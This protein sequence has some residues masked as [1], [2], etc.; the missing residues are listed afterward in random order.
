MEAAPRDSEFRKNVLTAWGTYKL[1][2]KVVN[3]AIGD[4]YQN[5]IDIIAVDPLKMSAANLCAKQNYKGY[6]N[7]FLPSYL[8]LGCIH[9]RLYQQGVGGFL[10]GGYYWS[11][12]END[13]DTAYASLFS[14]LISSMQRKDAKC[15]VR[16]AR[17]F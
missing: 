10:E 13:S 15:R 17:M 16:A 12:S 8:E 9:S 11:S 2:T 14:N 7:W 6:S 4:G 5:T 3:L 1:D